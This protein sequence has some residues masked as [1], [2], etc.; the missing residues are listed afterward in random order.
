MH[1]FLMGNVLGIIDHQNILTLAYAF[2]GA[3]ITRTSCNLPNLQLSRFGKS[4]YNYVKDVGY[5]P[6]GK[7][8]F[9]VRAEP[10]EDTEEDNNIMDV[11]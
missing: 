3:N 9:Y 2:T 10:N 4:S 1:S 7:M 6:V 8:V 11:L 5:L